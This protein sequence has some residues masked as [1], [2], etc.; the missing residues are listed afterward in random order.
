MEAMSHFILFLF[1]ERSPRGDCL[2][3]TFRWILALVFVG[4][5]HGTLLALPLDDPSYPAPL[6]KGTQ[7][8]AQQILDNHP[9]K[10]LTILTPLIRLYPDYT[11]V[12]TLAGMAYGKNGLNK[13]AIEMERR[14]LILDPQNVTARISLGIAEGN[15]GHFRQE[16]R[17]ENVVLREHPEKEA[18]WAALGWAY[19]SLGQWKEARFSEE[20]A[21]SIRPSDAG[22]RMILGLAL[23]HE[24][25]LQEALMMEKSAQKLSPSDEG[26]RRSLTYIKQEMNPPSQS[27][28]QKNGFNPL[29]APTLAPPSATATP[30]A[31]QQM[32]PS[33][34]R[35]PS[36]LH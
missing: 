15:T 19:G 5:G 13:K 35:A 16:V 10:A 3:W 34:I 7:Q 31:S 9:K 6:R 25:Y 21:I 12:F 4:T 28:K 11:V 18:A 14:A 32:S 20:K 23:A 27:K 30:G 24:G 8:A 33:P 36:V 1:P 2:R 26:I 29:L 22:A 17:E